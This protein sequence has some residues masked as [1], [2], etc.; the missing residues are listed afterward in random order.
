MMNHLSLSDTIT[1]DVFF[2]PPH[3]PTPRAKQLFQD[4]AA[5]SLQVTLIQVRPGTFTQESLQK[6]VDQLILLR[7]K[8]QETIDFPMKYGIFL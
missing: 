5:T 3:P 2:F 4:V 1:V 8:L 6:I 7:E